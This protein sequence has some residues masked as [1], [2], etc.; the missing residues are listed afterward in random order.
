MP[1]SI[2]SVKAEEHSNPETAQ[3]ASN[4]LKVV[5]EAAWGA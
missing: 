5:K 4:A 1:K 2:Q 3:K